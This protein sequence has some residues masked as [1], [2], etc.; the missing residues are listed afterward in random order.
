MP[1]PHLGRHFEDV[2]KLLDVLHHFVSL[3]NTVMVVVHNLDAIKSAD[4]VIGSGSG[5]R[6]EKAAE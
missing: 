5:R 3:V 4:W 6:R 2:R 1:R